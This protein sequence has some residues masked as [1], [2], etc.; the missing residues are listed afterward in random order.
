MLTWSF[1]H[2]S[3][4]APPTMCYFCL[5]F[6][7][8]YLLLAAIFSQGKSTSWHRNFRLLTLAQARICTPRYVT[9]P[10]ILP[11]SCMPLLGEAAQLSTSYQLAIVMKSILTSLSS[12]CLILQ[13]QA[14]GNIFREP[15]LCTPFHCL[16]NKYCYFFRIHLNLW[17]MQVLLTQ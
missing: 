12:P 15:Q 8:F 4:P 1:L 11:Q 2:D 14:V 10:L 13:P 17:N 5:F 6:Y 9:S 3:Y 7:I 16:K